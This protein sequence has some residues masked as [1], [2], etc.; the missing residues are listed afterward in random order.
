[1]KKLITYL[2]CIG[3]VIGL[4]AFAPVTMAAD[5]TA[6]TY[7]PS[8]S[9]GR[10]FI[11]PSTTLG[12]FTPTTA[13]VAA[14]TITFTLPVDTIITV[15]SVAP[16]DFTIE[17]A[18]SGGGTP[19]TATVPTGVVANA[20]A[21][22]L[23]FTVDA[24]SLSTAPNAGLGVVT[25]KMSAT[26][27]GDEIQNSAGPSSGLTFQVDTVVGDTGNIATVAFITATITSASDT[28]SDVTISTASSHT[29]TFVTP[30]GVP[31]ALTGGDTIVL[32]FPADFDFTGETIGDITFSHG[33]T[34]GLETP[35]TL[36]AVADA[37]D[38]GAVLSGATNLVLTL[39]APTDGLGAGV[40]AASDKIVITYAATNALNATTA[41]TYN[42]AVT[43]TFSNAG[44]IPV[45]VGPVAIAD[46]TC[47]SSGSAGAIWLRWTTPVGA[48]GAYV[49]KTSLAT[50]TA[51]NFDAVTANTFSQ[52]WVTG[53]IGVVQQRLVNALTPNNVY[54]FNVKA[55]G[56]TALSL[57][58][59]SNTVYC[60]APT[61]GSTG[62]SDTTAPTSTI[63]SPTESQGIKAGESFTITGTSS[64]TGGSSVSLVEISLDDGTTWYSTSAITS[65]ATGFDWNYIWSSP[66]LGSYTIKTR[67]TDGFG[68]IETPGDGVPVVVL[69]VVPSVTVEIGGPETDE[70][71]ADETPADETPA[72]ETPAA[73]PTIA[74]MEAFQ[75][76]ISNMR[77]QLVILLNQVLVMLQA[78]L[79]NY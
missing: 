30:T 7:T 48:T 40:I 46:L 63:T 8:G 1:M 53:T 32:T 19:G 51:G 56:V 55:G 17:Q 26:A 68:N 14:G 13:I 69:D 52:T 25:V 57:S 28:L 31:T 2:G 43:G 50:I 39:T 20:G 70:T 18:A 23:V 74:E 75:V 45:Y 9:V 3:L 60:T 10:S 65:T 21:R 15:A 79:S 36:V 59:I 24:A 42:V 62:A 61:A 76:V 71:P 49:A 34:T 27:T 29:L 35:E 67:A 4:L 58:K 41:N 72:D 37:T 11:Q 16:G 44:N 47:I 54:Y 22:T 6:I 5:V 77:E 38:W 66:A 64:D 12:I 73:E 78:L 33:A